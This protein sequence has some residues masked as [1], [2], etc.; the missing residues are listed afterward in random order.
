MC[1]NVFIKVFNVFIAKHNQTSNHSETPKRQTITPWPWPSLWPLLPPP[2]G[3]L[4]AGAL[5]D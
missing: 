2:I 4:F 5:N 1:I 3:D